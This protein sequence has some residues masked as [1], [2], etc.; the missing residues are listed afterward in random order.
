MN[1]LMFISPSHPMYWKLRF[2]VAAQLDFMNMELAN[3]TL[4]KGWSDEARQIMQ[5]DAQ[6]VLDKLYEVNR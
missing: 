3:P 6:E 1:D 2:V 4:T 5:K